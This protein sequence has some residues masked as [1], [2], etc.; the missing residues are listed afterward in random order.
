MLKW[1]IQNAADHEKITIAQ[2]KMEDYEN[3]L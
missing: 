2:E 3:I 1:I